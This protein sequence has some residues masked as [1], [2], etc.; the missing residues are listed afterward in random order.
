M[1]SEFAFEDLSSF[2]IDKYKFKYLGEEKINELDCY[3][4]ELIP[5][6]THSGYT[7]QIVWLDKEELR[8]QKIM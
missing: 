7:K 8:A 4:S 1:G 5:T 3:K 6:Y 2:E